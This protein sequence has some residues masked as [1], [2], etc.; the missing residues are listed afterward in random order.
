MLPQSH[1]K[2]LG[3]GYVENIGKS[4]FLK[5]SIDFLI[6]W[7][8]KYLMIWRYQTP[9][10]KISKYVQTEIPK[11]MIAKRKTLWSSSL[12]IKIAWLLILISRAAWPLA[13]F[14]FFFF[15]FAKDHEHLLANMCE[16]EGDA[17]A[18]QSHLEW[19]P[20]SP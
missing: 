1:S 18:Y 9:K 7:T 3:V 6:F 4:L 15:P 14:F 12:L 13:F 2:Y 10:N 16:C 20:I 11:Y 5:Y 19:K 8:P 17:S